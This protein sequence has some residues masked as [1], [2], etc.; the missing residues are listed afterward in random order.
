M[1]YRFIHK[2]THV[3]PEHNMVGG[4][5][6]RQRVTRIPQNWPPSFIAPI[7][8]E[9]ANL[10]LVAFGWLDPFSSRNFQDIFFLLFFPV[11]T[12]LHS[13]F[14]T[15]QGLSGQELQSHDDSVGRGLRHHGALQKENCGRFWMFV[16]SYF[17]GKLSRKGGSVMKISSAV[18]RCLFSL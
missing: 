9:N 8:N 2:A 11:N 7:S 10:C 1:L 15:L 5:T 17:A 13:A 3:W 4:G 18:R 6:S 12:L 16:L 14:L